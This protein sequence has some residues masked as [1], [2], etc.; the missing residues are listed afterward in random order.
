MNY[1]VQVIG[2]HEFNYG[3]EY[4]QAAIDSYQAP[5]LAAFKSD[6]LFPMWNILSNQSKNS[7]F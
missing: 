3:L 7:N 5:V 1:D 2:N 4:L 6:G